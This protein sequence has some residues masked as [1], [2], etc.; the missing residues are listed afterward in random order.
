MLHLV[1]PLFIVFAEPGFPLRDVAQLP[2]IAGAL[3]AT[4]V[5]DLQQALQPGR[6]LVWRHGST[7]PVELW[8]ALTGFLHN[9]GH[10]LYI[11]GEPFTVPVTGAAGARVEQPRNL[12]MLKAL[13]LNQCYR[14]HAGAETVVVLEPRLSDTKDFAHEDGAPGARD[15]LLRPFRYA[16]ADDPRFPAAATAYAI[17]HFRDAWAGSRWTFWLAARV[18][19]AEELAQLL[20]EAGKPPFDLRADPTFGCFHAGEQPSLLLRAHRP[21][22]AAAEEV[23]VT[24]HVTLPDGSRRELP[25]VRLRCGVHGQTRVAL[26]LDGKPGLY[27]VR[28]STAGAP[29]YETGFWIMDPEL[30]AGGEPLSFDRYTLRKGG[31]PFP[32]VGTTVMSATVHRKFLFEPNAASWDDTFRELAAIDV[33]L[34]RTGMWSAFRKL[35]LDPNALDEGC[36]RAL[37]AFYLSARRHDVAVLFTLF[38]FLP[39][40]WGGKNP[41]LDPRAIEGQRAYAGGLAARFAGCKHLLWDLINEPSFASAEKLWSC[42]P[43]GDAFEEKAFRA[44]LA[45]RHGA[46]WQTTV[47]ARWRLLP[48]APIG[49]PTQEDFADRHLFGEH[50]PYRAFDW[51]L[52][53]QDAFRGW[54]EQMRAAIRESGSQQP[55]TVGQDEGG[56]GQRPHPLFHHEAVEF[57]SIHTW[58]SNDALLWDGLCSK[59]PGKPLLVSETGIMQREQL[60]G[61]ALRAPED[62]AA[63]LARKIGHAFGAGAFGV[64]QWCYDVNPF[65]AIDNE[66]AIGLRRVDGSYKPEHKVFREVAA[67]VAR[68]RDWFEPP[69]EPRVVLVLPTSDLFSM[70]D[71]ATGATRRAVRV[72]VE[73]LGQPVQIV[74]EH[75]LASDLPDVGRIHLPACNGLAEPAWNRLQQAI[76]GG[77]RVSC[78]GWFE[79]DDAGLP[80]RR[81]GSAPRPLALVETFGQGALRFPLAVVESVHAAATP[82]SPPLHHAPVPLE[83]ADSDDGLREFLAADAA[84]PP[85]APGLTVRRFEVGSRRFVVAINESA[86]ATRVSGLADPG[87]VAAGGLLLA[88]QDAASGRVLASCRPTIAATS[89]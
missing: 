23:P 32:V 6:V 66:V 26:E 35:Q 74:A 58:W 39:E 70:R 44:W 27:R 1:A 36:V 21:R 47:R 51:V 4:S 76:A 24:L 9:G 59:A 75:R 86:V 5:A 64:V 15:A 19:G 65:M 38:A 84:Q 54:C 87:P 53:A 17:D 33:N 37:E 71:L 89:K 52:F 18:P 41:Y 45:Q 40:T 31:K 16:A 2:E 34:V 46:D 62:S 13:R 60:S 83:F 29:E 55:I 78:S 77:A 25:P 68:H 12:A 42:R 56:L 22:A 73:Q 50:K 82:A 81:L 67:F 43:N 48:D 79:A 10:L 8:P 3:A 49:L 61:A 88:W 28:A 30:F 80:A 14:V 72:W 69:A 7:F 85:P 11:G 63:L 20:A 57:T